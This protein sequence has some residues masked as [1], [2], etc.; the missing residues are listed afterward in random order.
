MSRLTVLDAFFTDH[1]HCGDLDAGVDSPKSGLLARAEREW[2]GGW[3][4]LY[5]LAFHD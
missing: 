1:N 3:T 2:R 5:A 4:R